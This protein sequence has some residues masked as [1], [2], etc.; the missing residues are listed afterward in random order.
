M[1][2]STENHGQNKVELMELHDDFKVTFN[3]TDCV[4]LNSEEIPHQQPMTPGQPMTPQQHVQLQQQVMQQSM[5]SPAPSMTSHQAQGSMTPQSRSMTP[6][7]PA[8]VMTPQQHPGNMTPQPHV[9]MTPQTVVMTPGV[10]T[11]Q[12]GGM[13]PQQGG[14]TPSYQQHSTI[15][16]QPH[17]V[18][19]Q[20]S[21]GQM[22]ETATSIGQP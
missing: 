16:Q 3:Q 18:S 6:Q 9:A 13:T 17:G 2:Y 11:P 15:I 20:I 10:M 21:R 1:F 12:Q 4:E 22:D 14:M 19:M 7:Q 5:T 8:V